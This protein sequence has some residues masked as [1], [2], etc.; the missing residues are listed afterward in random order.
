[1]MT[2]LGLSES[3]T[4]QV[5]SAAGLAPSLFNT[6]PWRFRLCPDR[7]EVHPDRGRRLIAH[8]PEDRELRI[9]CGAALFNLRLAVHAHGVTPVVTIEPGDLPEALAVI[10][11]GPVTVQS[12]DD[13]ALHQAI[14]QRR[15]NRHPFLDAPMPEAY[16]RVLTFAAA[17]EGADLRTITTPAE[18]FELRCIIA[19]ADQR[20]HDNVVCRAE[21]EAWTGYRDGHPDGVPL[22]AAGPRPEPQDPWAFR[23][24]GN[25][26]ARPRTEDFE[27]E[28]FVVV[29]ST[30]MDGPGCQV[31]AGQA[32]QRV[33]LTATVLG[34]AASFLSQPIEVSDE[35][36]ELRRLL[37]DGRHPQAVLRLGFGAPVA[38]TPR[39]DAADLLLPEPV[40]ST[41]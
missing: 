4:R 41:H 16:R 24:M 18:R 13:A 27:A 19:A 17:A 36:R 35:R 2:A 31:Q 32:L 29:L 1:M 22:A 28:P 8:D 40:G 15:T 26:F 7:I 23:D 5:V 25:G 3:A 21:L 6:Q 12:R 33:L 30:R 14:K 11:R 39:R 9:A 10:R 38:G 20:Q 34:L 37:A